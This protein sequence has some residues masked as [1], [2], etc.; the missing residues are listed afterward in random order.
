MATLAGRF[1]A[2]AKSQALA[3]LATGEKPD[4]ETLARRIRQGPLHGKVTVDGVEMHLEPLSPSIGTVVHGVDLAALTPELRDFLRGLWLQRKALFFRG[5][6]HLTRQQHVELAEQFGTVGA[7][8]GERDW[9]PENQLISLK[10]AT[11]AGFPDI[12]RIYSDEKSLGAA[13]AWHS[14]VMWSSR[15]PM[16]SM[17]LA[18][19]VP[20]VGGD[21]CFCDMYAMW[22]GLRPQTRRRLEGL[23][24]VNVGSAVHMRDGKVP[25][26]EHPCARTHPETGCTGLYVSP[27]FTR[28]II[29]VSKE[30]NRALLGECFAQA[31]MPE[32]CCRFR[33]EV[34]SL[35]FW[36]NRACLHYA[37]PDSWPYTRHLERVTVLDRDESKKAP[38]YAG[39]AKL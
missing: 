14:D 5:Q 34:G 23:R 18:R 9:V 29:G 26:A 33:W 13:A 15:P 1:M 37:T 2:V 10:T 19:K 17:L 20:P 25:R 8:H 36:D 30:E 4:K 31:G 6:S 16:G 22:E 7:H 21:T 11:P 35:A 27:G 12:I 3:L 24:A 38:Y 32:Y 28:R 39:P